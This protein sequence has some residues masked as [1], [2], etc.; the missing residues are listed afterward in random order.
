MEDDRRR[1]EVALV[2]F[3]VNQQEHFNT[4]ILL[5]EKDGQYYL[6]NMVPPLGTPIYK[7]AGALLKTYTNLQAIEDKVG[8][9]ILKQLSIEEY[10]EVIVIPFG[11]MIPESIKLE[12]NAR[13]IT[14]SKFIELNETQKMSEATKNIIQTSVMQ[15]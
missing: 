9:V 4:K 10:G 13:W 6:P 5:L 15:V 2:I 3:A 11:C 14:F 8:W 12:Y 7:V 1:V